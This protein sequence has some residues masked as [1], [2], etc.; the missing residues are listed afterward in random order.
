MGKL[1]LNNEFR[2]SI[3]E[4]LA[5]LVQPP[6]LLTHCRQLLVAEADRAVN[7]DA[8]CVGRDLPRSFSLL[9]LSDAQGR[10]CQPHVIDQEMEA[11]EGKGAH[12]ESLCQIGAPGSLL[13]SPDATLLSGASSGPLDTAHHTPGHLRTAGGDGPGQP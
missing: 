7:G 5:E 11:F 4:L 3:R 6:G 1:R 8:V 2:A 9:I 13:S 10:D 12:P